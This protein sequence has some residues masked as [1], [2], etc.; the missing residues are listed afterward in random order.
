[1]SSVLLQLFLFSP[2]TVAIPFKF[3][4]VVITLLLIFFTLA[5]CIHIYTWWTKRLKLT[6]LSFFGVIV[7][8]PV[9]ICKGAWGW[10]QS[11]IADLILSAVNLLCFCM[12]PF[13]TY[14]YTFPFFAFTANNYLLKNINRP[15]N[16]WWFFVIKCTPSAPTYNKAREGGS[17]ARLLVVL[18]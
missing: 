5:S 2:H 15:A 11:S 10:L 12:L 14:N 17:V 4:H 1:M 18:S 8:P 16:E 6:K 13:I 7:S 3:L 9:N